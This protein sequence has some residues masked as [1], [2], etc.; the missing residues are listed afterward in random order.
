MFVDC[1]QIIRLVLVVVKTVGRMYTERVVNAEE[2]EEA[3]TI[4]LQSASYKR[5]VELSNPY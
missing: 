1:V 4:W 2:K 3:V 5:A